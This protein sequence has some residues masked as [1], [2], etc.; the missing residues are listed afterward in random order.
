M[1]LNDVAANALAPAI[2]SVRRRA[3]ISIVILVGAIGAIVE[4]TI[5]ATLALEPQMGLV[6]ARL[7]VAAIYA[8]LILMAVLIFVIS[9]RRASPAA[10]TSAP[11]RTAQLAENQGRVTLIAEAVFLG[12]SLARRARRE[13][14]DR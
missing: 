6:G 11:L 4:L 13:F 3:I 8:F 1:R 7:I 2:A 14:E 9:E 10:A 5:A 12:Y